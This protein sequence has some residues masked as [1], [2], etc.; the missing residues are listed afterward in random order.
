M[1]DLVSASAI[2]VHG[3]RV[4]FYVHG[5]AAFDI[6]YSELRRVA[7]R[8]FGQVLLQ[9]SMRRGLEPGGAVVG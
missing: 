4:V 9:I 6:D 1:T 7:S 8:P 3:E 5:R 2:S